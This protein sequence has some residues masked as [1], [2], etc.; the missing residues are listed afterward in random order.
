[1]NQHRL[2]VQLMNFRFHQQHQHHRHR[3]FH[4]QEQMNH[5][6]YRQQSL[7]QGLPRQE[8]APPRRKARAQI[9]RGLV[10]FAGGDQ[11]LGGCN[12]VFIKQGDKDRC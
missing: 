7:D 9:P 10:R 2:M 11:R 5:K 3:L 4:K 1:M 8:A 6:S 12:R